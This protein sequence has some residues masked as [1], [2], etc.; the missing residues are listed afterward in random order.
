MIPGPLRL[1]DAALLDAVSN[2]AKASP[3]QR[4]NRNFHPTDNHPGHRLLNAIEPGSYVAP[5][6]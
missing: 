1:I 4:K 5:H 6:R 2:E 3:R